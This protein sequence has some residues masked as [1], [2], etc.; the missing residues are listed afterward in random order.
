MGKTMALT[1]IEEYEL[2]SMRETIGVMTSREALE[3][4][5][6]YEEHR[7]DLGPF[8][9]AFGCFVSQQDIFEKYALLLEKEEQS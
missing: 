7:K 6:M 5:I 1:K 3:L 8:D 9:P 2:K 4:A